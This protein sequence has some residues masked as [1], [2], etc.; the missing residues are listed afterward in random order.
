MPV[1]LSALDIVPDDRDPQAIVDE[2]VTTMQ[3]QLPGWTPRSGTLEVLLMEALATGVAD[4]IYA[5]NRLPGVVLEAII[6]LLGVERYPG[7][8]STGTVT[9]TFVGPGAYNI[10][11][12]T[13]FAIP[14]RDDVALLTTAPAS[15]PGPTLTVPVATDVPGSVVVPAGTGLDAVDV[16]PDVLAITVQTE[17]TGGAAPESDAAYIARAR[18]RL[19]R[20]TS[21]LA[22]PPEFAAAA[23]DDP[24]VSRAATVDLWDG[25]S[26]AAIGTHPGHTTVAV[27]GPAGAVPAPARDEITAALAAKAVAILQVHVVPAIVST[28]NVAASIRVLP[29]FSP[30]L[31]VQD[32]QAAVRSWLDPASWE[33]GEPVRTLALAALIASVEG[34]D[35]VAALT[36]NV[37]VALTPALG[38]AQAGT[39]TVTVVT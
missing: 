21:T 35:Y 16:L 15:G 11:A 17:V 23:I 24:R 38:L 27:H 1:D 30:T 29:G 39:V 18:S 33:W 34:V 10:P 32:V 8:P 37:D 13:R 19:A 2:M 31:V 26:P 5:A 12:G 22:T 20:L 3:E 25:V 9:V 14:G 4:A 7:A 36:P 28:V 6:T